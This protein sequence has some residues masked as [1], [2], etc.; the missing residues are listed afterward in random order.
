M[1]DPQ[2]WQRLAELL[3][4]AVG[5]EVA[6]SGRPTWVVVLDD[7]EEPDGF[8][9]T[10]NDHP[11]GLIGWVAPADGLAVGVIASGRLRVLDG[12]DEPRL[13][14]RESTSPSCPGVGLPEEDSRV[15]M[16]CLVAR[17]GSTAWQMRLPDGVE[18]DYPP[19]EGRLLDCLRRCLE[20]PTPPPPAGPGVLQAV[21][22]S[23]AVLEA[24]RQSS[25]PLRWSE[26]TRL[27][28]VARLVAGEL[29]TDCSA[30]L[31]ALTRLAGAT[32][33]WADLRRQAQ[34]SD[35]LGGVDPELAAWMDDGM[36]ARWVLSV[37]PSP[38]E[39]LVTVRPYL[40][41]SAA[42]RM[43]HAIRACAELPSATS[44]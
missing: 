22:W 24:G 25:R 38:D 37:L 35:G 33:S 3:L 19:S 4:E 27:H 5:D 36:F 28:P 13:D 34:E 30:A 9:L 31:P 44:A 7:P 14:G 40:V 11:Y 12:A 43:A 6:A 23:A 18:A 15:R 20:L 32:W 39:M 10:F 29:D 16:A 8:R 2:A 42:R 26:V 17:D 41:P 1:A 21:A